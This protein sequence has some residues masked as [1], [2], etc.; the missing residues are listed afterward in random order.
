[1]ICR[2]LSGT[3]R[4]ELTPVDNR[5][6]ADHMPGAPG[7]AVQVYLYGLMQCYHQSM[8]DIS[9]S[10]AL[11]VTDEEV[12]K[13][14]AYWQSQRLVDITGT[15]PLIVEYRP[16]STLETSEVK[17]GKY[18]NLIRS[19]QTLTAPRQLTARELAEVYAWIEDYGLEEGAA[20][21]LFSY[22][23]ELK[24]NCSVNYMSAVARSWVEQGV[25]TQQDAIAHLAV[26]RARRSG[27]A[28]ILKAWRLR[29]PPTEDETK[30]YEKWT[31]EWGFTPEAIESVLPRMSR[32]Y[33]PSFDKLEQ[34]LFELYQQGKASSEA[35]LLEDREEDL[36]RRFARE[37]FARAGKAEPPTRT[38][39]R[40]IAMYVNDYGMPEELLFLAADMAKG[41]N[42]PFGRMKKLLNAWHEEQINTPGEAKRFEASRQTAP[43]GKKA[44]S[45]GYPQRSYSEKELE[46][47]AVNLDEDL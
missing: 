9:V 34:M 43:R 22:C 4:H 47:L 14:F 37:L 29:R 15:D 16:F 7:L 38:Q 28:R 18:V 26:D 33:A 24:K 35:V 10:E 21:A 42:E 17:P 44:K 6:I 31:R 8:A 12:E 23:L 1:M 11:G 39:V 25:F 13:A 30:R 45:L 40:Q 19:I 27:A 20:L 36:S 3:A 32:S 2:F 41:A 46:G 5:F